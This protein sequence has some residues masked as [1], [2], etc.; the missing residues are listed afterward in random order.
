M[1]KEIPLTQGMAAIVDDKDYDDLI[2][3]KWHSHKER[4]GRYYAKR[5]S[6]KINGV[7][8][9]ICMHR[10][11]LQVPPGADTDHINGNG[12][13]NRRINLRICSRSENM[14]N[15]VHKVPHTS[16]YKGVCWDSTHSKWLAQI[17]HHRSRIYLGRFDDEKEAAHAVD[18]KAKELFGEFAHLNFPDKK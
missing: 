13:D 7:Q 1:V 9:S 5:M 11:I 12:L 8:K 2:K 10:E 4:S 3:Y 16:N 15:S 18:I 17:C 14:A 6:N